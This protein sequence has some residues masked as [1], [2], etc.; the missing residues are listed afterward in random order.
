[1]QLRLRRTSA[2]LLGG[3]LLLAALAPSA[4]A[5]LNRPVPF[6]RQPTGL[7][8][9][10]AQP[11]DSEDTGY[12]GQ[13]AC[14]PRVLPGVRKL[15]DLAI[16][17]YG[18]GSLSGVIRSCVSGGQSEHKEG[19]AWDWMLSVADPA[20]KAVAG[21]FLAWLTKK[22]PDGRPGLQARRLGVMYVIYNRRIWRTY[23]PGW[24]TYTG[25]VPHT[26][27]IH[28]S[29]TWAG[30]RARTSF[31]T[32]TVAE[33][34]LGPCVVFSGQLARLT[35]RPNTR[36]CRAAV[37]AVRG[38][39]RPVVMYGVSGSQTVR[40]AQRMLGAPVT[41]TFDRRTWRSVKAYQ[42]AH[43]LPMTGVVDKLTWSSLVPA[44]VTDSVT[45]GFGPRRAARYGGN[46][47]G[48]LALHRGSAGRPVAFLQTALQLPEADRN[49]LLAGRTAAA[50]RAFKAD[51][52]LVRNAVVDAEVWHVLLASL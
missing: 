21:D 20:Q 38:S 46:H 35:T 45:D 2:L 50:V 26:D 7:T 5:V 28:I 3:C 1:M 36:G 34:D 9:P 4:G 27:H 49:G 11:A 6:P 10:V 32:G 30:A 24:D 14:I 52:G 48:R 16:R 47:F 23:R 22:G 15:R 31:W 29:F 44:S 40:N 19:R 12:A 17:T 25:A 18:M 13:N 41:G 33:N 51:H 37:A 42:A 8:A 43:D 39:R